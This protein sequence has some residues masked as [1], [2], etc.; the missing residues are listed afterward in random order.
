VRRTVA[1]VAECAHKP[2]VPEAKNRP[3]VEAIRF[4]VTEPHPQRTKRRISCWFPPALRFLLVL[5]SVPGYH[6]PMAEKKNTRAKWYAVWGSAWGPIGA[7]ATDRGVCTV[8]LPHYTFDDLRA[9]LA[10][11]HPNAAEDTAPFAELMDRTDEY[12]SAK[13]TRFDDIACDLP[14]EKTFAGK[15]LRAL[16]EIPFAQTRSYREVSLAIGRE[17][18]AR[19][20]ATAVGKNPVPLVVP[21]HRVIYSSGK[22]GGFSAEGGTDLKQRMLDLEQRA[23]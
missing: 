11:N 22:L 6:T 23:K 4:D 12:F 14:G 7:A 20:V 15:V 2:P 3:G 8:A 5:L 18:A 17:D 16:R 21:C 9:L 19:A 13:V 1:K 10:W